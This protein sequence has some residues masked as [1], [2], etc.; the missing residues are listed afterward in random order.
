MK[1]MAVGKKTREHR[2]ERKP[3][4]EGR[5]RGGPHKG[6]MSYEKEREGTRAGVLKWHTHS[7]RSEIG[8][9]TDLP[10]D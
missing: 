2:N 9:V 6:D 1:R 5:E 8:A 7:S 3:A 10:A 4:W